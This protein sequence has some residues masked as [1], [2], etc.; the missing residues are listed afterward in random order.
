MQE[1]KSKSN[2]SKKDKITPWPGEYK[3]NNEI[4]LW[5]KYSIRKKLKKSKKDDFPGPGSYNINTVIFNGPSYIMG[6]REKEKAIDKKSLKDN[7]PLQIE[8]SANKEIRG[9]SFPK[10]VFKIKLN[11]WFLGWSI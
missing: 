4:G 8:S 11:L 3:I 1:K 5:P 6:A 10:A 9:F 2:N 7:E